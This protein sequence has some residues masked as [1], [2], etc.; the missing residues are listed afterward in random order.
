MFLLCERE[1]SYVSAGNLLWVFVFLCLVEYA[2]N[3]RTW[4]LF[5][6]AISQDCV[7]SRQPWGMGI[8][9]QRV[10]SLIAWYETS[11]SPKVCIP[12][13]WRNTLYIQH[14]C[15]I[16]GLLGCLTVVSWDSRTKRCDADMGMQ[17]GMLLAML[18]VI[19]LPSLTQQS[20]VFC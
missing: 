1:R 13:V 3:I 2:K 15:W 5:T 4:Q 16:Y 11:R 12:Q 7:C 14:E 19:K 8:M 18:S 6:D 9:G 10:D 20:L 17:M